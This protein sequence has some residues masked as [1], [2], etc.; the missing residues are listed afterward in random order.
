[1]ERIPDWQLE[2]YALGELPP[3]RL[4]AIRARL[5][6]DPALAA[7]LAAL[8]ADDQA[9]LGAWPPAR[10]VPGLEARSA[11]R[12]S[13]A[14]WWRLGWIVPALAMAAVF[15]VTR[16]APEPPL[17][18]AHTTATPPE[19]H[20]RVKGVSPELRVYRNTGGRV[21]R[22]A[23]GAAA[24][25]GDLLQLGY[26]AAGAAY[27]VVVSIDGNGVVTDHAQG[28]DGDALAL[29]RS[30]EVPLVSAY[31]LDAAPRFE[32]F[33]LVTSDAPFDAAVVRAAA[34]DLAADPASATAPLD[35]PAPL[36][37]TSLTL[38]KEPR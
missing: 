20:G 25:A 38:M 16:P 35:L 23:G 6:T 8:R 11:A 18:D 12:E 26:V 2:R 24:H 30:G 15:V 36:A 21:E 14:A 9:F 3:E 34:E 22:L 31:E 7:R 5:D 27:G 4:A 1:M 17:T 19:E 29:D 37:Q 32:R 13:G 33:F 28:P 10:V